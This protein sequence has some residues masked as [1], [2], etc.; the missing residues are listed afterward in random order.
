LKDYNDNFKNEVPTIG[1]PNPMMIEKK[2]RDLLTMMF[3]SKC[4][5]NSMIA[6]D[7]FTDIVQTIG[8]KKGQSP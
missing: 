1:L 8:L 2:N 5:A 6:F 4:K 3:K 7:D